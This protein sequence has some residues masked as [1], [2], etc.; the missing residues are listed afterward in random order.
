MKPA[1]QHDE[2]AAGRSW[3]GQ[4]IPLPVGDL[5]RALSSEPVPGHLKRWWWGLGG[6]AAIFLAIQIATG[7][8]L[9]FYYVPDPDAAW[10]SVRHITQDVPF[11]W[12][13]RSLHK[14]AANGMVVAVIL[15]AMR[16]FFTGAYRAPRELNWVVGSLILIVTLVMGFTGYSL[17]Y[18]QLSYWGAT[19]AGNLT[20]AAPLVGPLLAGLLRGGDAVSGNT[21]TRF[22]VLHIGVLPT[23]LIGLLIVHFVLIRALGVTEYRFRD[24]ERS[25]A[26]KTYPFFPDHF[27][28]EVIIGLGLLIGVTCIAVIFPAGL[29]ERANPLVT[30]EH[31]KPEWYFYWTFRWLKLVG[32]QTAIATLGMAA[33]LFVLWPFIDGALRRRRPGSELSVALGAL[34]VVVLL[35]MTVWEAVLLSH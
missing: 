20:E 17:I 31:I 30:P 29:E 10:E 13:L 1:T 14:W 18:E 27:M 24:D 7:I 6:T 16:V 11:G 26:A 15:H 12:Y 19:V 34:A 3:I 8:L 32:L 22:H 35:V 4:R 23:I 21:L 5:F 2:P 33:G 9:S 25:G 28:T